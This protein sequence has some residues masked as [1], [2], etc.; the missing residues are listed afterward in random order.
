M[1]KHLTKVLIEHIEA[2]NALSKKFPQI[3]SILLTKITTENSKAIAESYTG[4][5]LT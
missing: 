2:R 4:R 3:L 5:G 1:I